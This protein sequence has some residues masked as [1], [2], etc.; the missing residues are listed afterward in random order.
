MKKLQKLTLLRSTPLTIPQMKR[1]TGGY[2]DPTGT[3]GFTGTFPAIFYNPNNGETRTMTVCDLSYD[4][5]QIMRGF[6]I[7]DFNWCCVHCAG[8]GYCGDGSGGGKIYG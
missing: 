5:V 1:I 6:A 8:S 7:S 3:C 4:E 2:G